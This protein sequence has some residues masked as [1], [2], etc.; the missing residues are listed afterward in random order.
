MTAL[1]P[2]RAAPKSVPAT[3]FPAS[4]LRVTFGPRATTPADPP[5]MSPVALTVTDPVAPKSKAETPEL[6]PLTSPLFT[7]IG[8]P[9]V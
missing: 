3:V 6:G 7:V 5:V 1:I 4:T 2:V 9:L 8:P